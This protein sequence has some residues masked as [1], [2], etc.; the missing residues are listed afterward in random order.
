MFK[1]KTSSQKQL[2]DKVLEINSLRE[3]QERFRK[4]KNIMSGLL[5]QVQKDISLK[6]CSSFG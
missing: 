4:D 1:L 2:N 6:V 5:T 3:E